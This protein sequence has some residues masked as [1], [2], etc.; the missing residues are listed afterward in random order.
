[1]T[2]DNEYAMWNAHQNQYGQR[3][4]VHQSGNI[5]FELFGDGHC[6]EIE[7][8]AVWRLERLGAASDSSSREGSALAYQQTGRD[9]KDR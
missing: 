7:R 3:Y 2:Q 8:M 5:V 1:V 9:G 4:F 6:E